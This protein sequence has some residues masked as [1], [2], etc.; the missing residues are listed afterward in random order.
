LITNFGKDDSIAKVIE[1]IG[2]VQ[3]A[4]T[5]SSIND[6]AYAMLKGGY[7]AAEFKAEQFL[8]TDGYSDLMRVLI[9]MEKR[10]VH[11]EAA[12]EVLMKI[13]HIKA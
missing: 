5:Q 12:A 4:F 7:T 13:F 11:P 6:L 9:I 1:E 10:M 8:G 2:I 3:A